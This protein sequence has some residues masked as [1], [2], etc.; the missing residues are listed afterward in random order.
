M[1]TYFCA[2]I[3]RNMIPHMAAWIDSHGEGSKIISFISTSSGFGPFET[4][5]YEVVGSINGTID[6]DKFKMQFG[7]FSNLETYTSKN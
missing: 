7:F 3:S 5:S 2:H 1:K 4:T 6:K